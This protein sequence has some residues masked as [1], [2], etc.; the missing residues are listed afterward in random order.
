MSEPTI[1]TAVLGTLAALLG[2]ATAVYR[3]LWLRAEN[4]VDGYRMG[5]ADARVKRLME[6]VDRA[7]L[8]ACDSRAREQAARRELGAMRADRDAGIAA[9][10]KWG[11]E[12][13]AGKWVF[14]E[15]RK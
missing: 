5:G 14:V 12:L 13:Q 3:S 15:D 7:R 6:E 10:E 4:V 11:E 9:L 2:I 1:A 8:E